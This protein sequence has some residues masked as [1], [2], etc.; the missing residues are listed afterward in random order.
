MYLCK[1]E[2]TS[3]AYHPDVY[4]RSSQSYCIFIMFHVKHFE[5]CYTVSVTD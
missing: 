2:H 4:A 3:L 5:M 1:S